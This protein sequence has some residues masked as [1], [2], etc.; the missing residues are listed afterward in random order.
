MADSH[1]EQSTVESEKTISAAT[2]MPE[3]TPLIPRFLE[4]AKI[5]YRP[6]SVHMFRR[7]LKLYPMCEGPEHYRAIRLQT[8]LARS[9]VNM[10][11]RYLSSFLYWAARHGAP[12]P[13]LPKQL[14]EVKTKKRIIDVAEFETLLK[15]CRSW[16][17]W[18]MLNLGF[19]CGLRGSEI[20]HLEASDFSPAG[21]TIRAKPQWN[22]IPKDGQERTVPI[23]FMVPE[24]PEGLIFSVNGHPHIIQWLQL[25]AIC[26]RAKVPRITMHCLRHSYATRLMRSGIDV[27]TVQYL[28]GHNSLN[29]TMRYL[30]PHPDAAELVCKAFD[31]NPASL[32]NEKKDV[33]TSPQQQDHIAR[34][35]ERLDK[36]EDE[37]Q[38]HLAEQLHAYVDHRETHGDQPEAAPIERLSARE[39]QIAE[40]ASAGRKNRE[41]AAQ[42]S[43]SENTVKRHIQN[44]FAKTGERVRLIG[45]AAAD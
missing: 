14:R 19:K 44:I 30:E 31:A 23:P 5:L 18:L 33:V 29:T 13:F 8:G 26:N 41:I 28:L 1:E 22:F 4:Q 17:Q 36:S 27:R 37:I 11:M 35:L 24:L 9:S 21:V 34:R 25:K 3:L 45:L 16:R 38:R 40:L 32:Q 39:R 2:T 15:G 10:E 12:Q 6:N 7:V 20:W 42:L 43:L